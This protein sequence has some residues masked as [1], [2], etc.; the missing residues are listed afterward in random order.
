MIGPTTA[1]F[2]S[3]LWQ[4]LCPLHHHLPRHPTAG[5]LRPNYS[6]IELIGHR[7]ACGLE[8]RLR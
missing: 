8:F 2:R 4:R 1:R 7:T 3:K 6:D 5:Q